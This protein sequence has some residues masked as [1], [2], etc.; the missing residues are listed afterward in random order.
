MFGQKLVEWLLWRTVDLSIFLV[1]ALLFVRHQLRLLRATTLVPARLP[2]APASGLADPRPS[3][4]ARRA[5]WRTDV[6]VQL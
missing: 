4:A 3:P 2:L 6:R 5:R 1:V